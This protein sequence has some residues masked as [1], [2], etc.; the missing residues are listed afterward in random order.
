MDNGAYGKGDNV[1]NANGGVVFFD[2]EEIKQSTKYVTCVGSISSGWQTII[3]ISAFALSFVVGFVAGYITA[4]PMIGMAVG[5]L[6]GAGLG[7]G[8]S[9][10]IIAFSYDA[11][12]DR[13]GLATRMTFGCMA[14]G[15]LGGVLGSAV[16][17]YGPAQ[18]EVDAGAV[19]EG[20]PEVVEFIDAPMEAGQG[21][22]G[23]D[24]C[25]ISEFSDI[26][27]NSGSILSNVAEFVSES[28]SE[29]SSVIG[30]ISFITVWY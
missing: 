22:I 14:V 24:M 2:G 16:S 10:I 9:A 11:K 26:A 8:S 5:G 15:M 6:V 20:N 30:D 12:M 21:F 13:L 27:S 29:I 4:N 18:F 28:A 23:P 7:L 19:A 25:A 1:C 3:K 17:P